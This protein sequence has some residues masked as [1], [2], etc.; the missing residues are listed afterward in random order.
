M[1]PDG[2]L[3]IACMVLRSLDLMVVGPGPMSRLFLPKAKVGISLTLI[4]PGLL[5]RTCPGN[6]V[7]LT[8]YPSLYVLRYFTLVVFFI[9]SLSLHDV[10]LPYCC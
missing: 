3:V 4:H 6:P 2:L 10:F 5:F 1:D 8:R 7:T 9:S